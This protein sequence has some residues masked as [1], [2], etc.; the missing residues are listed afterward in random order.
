MPG[1]NKIPKG[2]AQ[3]NVLISEKLKNKLIDLVKVKYPSLR[4]GLS[5]E[6]ENA[7]AHWIS[8]HTQKHTNSS[9][10]NKINPLPKAK[11][12]FEQIKVYLKEKYGF[13]PQ[14]VTYRDLEEAIS[15][16]RGSDKRTVRKW[17]NEFIKWKLIKH[18]VGQVYE[19][20]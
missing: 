12:V 10:I 16:V 15:M 17:M 8:L 3:L 2:K 4:G 6:V 14:Q 7:L 18:I 20:V 5:T 13:P 9:Q 19:I 11:V 1:R